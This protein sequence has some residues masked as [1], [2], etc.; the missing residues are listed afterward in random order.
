VAG[1]LSLVLN[2]F[3]TVIA[4]EADQEFGMNACV[5]SAQYVRHTADNFG[6]AGMVLSGS[7]WL[8]GIGVQF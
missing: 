6:K 2:F 3:D 5:L 4:R 7:Y 8:F 1:G